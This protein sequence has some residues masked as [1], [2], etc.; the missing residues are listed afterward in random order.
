[1]LEQIPEVCLCLAS[2]LDGRISQEQGQSPNF[3]SRYDREKLFRLRSRSDALLIGANTVREERLS[4]VIRN[5]DLVKER[6]ER[7]QDAHPHAVIVSASRKLPLESAYFR[8]TRQKRYLLTSQIPESE[9]AAFENA[10]LNLLETGDSLSLRKGLSLLYATGVRKVLAEG[11]G[12]LNHALLRDDL[13]DWVHLTIAPVFIAGANTPLL[14]SGPS[15]KPLPR[16][17]LTKCE[18]VED[19]LHLEYH[20]CRN[21]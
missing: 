20:R 18:Q 19:E 3:T 13:V 6:L 2:S 7:G 10:G 21:P 15:F 1:M 17:N 12:I 16:F 4:P 8:D 5:E 11:G 9:R 14:C